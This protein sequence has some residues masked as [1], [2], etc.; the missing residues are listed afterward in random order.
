MSGICLNVLALG[1]AT[2]CFDFGVGNN[3]FNL[4]NIFQFWVGNNG[5]W[6]S[7]YF[8]FVFGNNVFGFIN[9]C[10]LWFGLVGLVFFSFP[11]I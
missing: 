1:F 4:P 3:E 5:S 2:I 10:G 11:K 7:H 6:V 9:I 8:Y